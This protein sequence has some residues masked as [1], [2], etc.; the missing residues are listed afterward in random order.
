MPNRR[1]PLSALAVAALL[2]GPATGH[3]QRN[4]DRTTTPVKHVIVLIGENRSFDHIYAT[5]Q[6]RS[7][8]RI[9]NLLAKG[10]VNA[11]GSPGPRFA[12][13]A[14]Y[15]ATDTDKYHISP[16]RT[17]PYATLPP[18]STGGTPQEQTAT[19]TPFKTLE[20]ARAATD[21][22]LPEDLVLLTTGASGLPRNE[23]DIRI[24]NVHALPNGPFPLT[25]GIP[26]DAF[27][28][29]PVHRFY[30]A[31]QQADCAVA[32]VTPDNP[33]G[34]RNDLYPWVAVTAGGGSN[35]APP[36]AGFNDQ[37]T[38]EGATAMGFYNMARGDS[39]YLRRL[40]DTYAISDNYHQPAMGGTGLNSIVAGF[41]DAIWYSDGRGHPARPPQAQV[42]NPNPMPHTN[43]WYTQDGY[44][45]R[46]TGQGG[47]SY[48]ACADANA[49]GVGAILGYLAAL[50]ARPNP[51]CEV[52]LWYLVNNYAPGFN[53]DGSLNTSGPFVLPPV[54]ARSIGDVLL[55]GGVSFAWFGEGYNRAVANPGKYLG[56]C[57]VC[58]PFN[59]Q[60]RFMADPK[61]RPAATK[62]TA[63]FYAALHDGDLP[64]VSFVKP[65]GVTDGHPT[66]SKW[67]IFE[68][69]AR[70]LMT[71]LRKRPDLWATTVVF[72]TVD[73]GGGYWD[74]G[75][76][77]PLD[78]FGDG[79]RIPMIVVSRWSRGGQVSHAYSDHVSILKFIEKNWGLKTISGRSR[80]NLPNP[81]VAAGNPYVPV[82]GPA[83]ADM[84]DYFDFRHPVD[85][86][87]GRDGAGVE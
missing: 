7:G 15:Q 57:D 69:Y 75:Y 50:P 21:D 10:I 20:Q 24:P 39:P 2:A 41:A 61:L 23:I 18:V 74:S 28:S 46:K 9:D 73:E 35:G 36:P 76:I 59:Y 55:E 6:P 11:D 72:I 5:Y 70:K 51:N 48:T 30:Q 60:T 34:C 38:H 78:F 31:W 25:P 66:S 3:A 12:L 49:P 54:P 52:G 33:S 19:R 79:P 67:S 22:L 83:I 16:A 53:A 85:G 65:G 80:D 32:H 4:D 58:N 27:T 14:Q 17:A 87:E 43:N 8:A 42:E 86:G 13:A 37:S 68:A 45:I 56:Y 29:N 82:N 84:M 77:Q 64:A 71:E 47:G 63:D 1:N 44:G 26:Y 40:S 62:D 81:V